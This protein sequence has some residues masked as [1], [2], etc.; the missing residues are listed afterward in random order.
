MSSGLVFVSM[1]PCV[2]NSGTSEPSACV[3][4]SRAFQYSDSGSAISPS[5]EFCAVHSGCA[6][7]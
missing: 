6:F 7:S 2:T 4:R 1:K 5:A 3:A